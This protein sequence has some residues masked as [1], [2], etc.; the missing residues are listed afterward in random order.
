MAAIT[1]TITVFLVKS[2]WPWFVKNVW[3]LIRE[4]VIAESVAALKAMVKALKESFNRRMKSR[5]EEAIKKATV[6]EQLASTSGTEAERREH[7]AVARV[8]REVA[9]QFRQENESLKA[10]LGEVTQRAEQAMKAN[11]ALADPQIS[12][13]GSSPVLVLG[14]NETHLP[15]LTY[16]KQSE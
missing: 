4:Y 5:Q 2:F 9:E 12:E 14:G 13:I 7:E 3:P 6:A 15:A 11:V 10:K 1:K 8:W 16:T